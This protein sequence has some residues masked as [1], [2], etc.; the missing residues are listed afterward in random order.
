MAWT[1]RLRQNGVEK[2]CE[3]RRACFSELFSDF[4]ATRFDM[5]LMIED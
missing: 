4:R 1:L 5:N 3:N 2:P